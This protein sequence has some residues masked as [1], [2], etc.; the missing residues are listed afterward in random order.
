MRRNEGRLAILVDPGLKAKMGTLSLSRSLGFLFTN[1]FNFFKK[2][3]FFFYHVLY[4]IFARIL[5]MEWL[6]EISLLRSFTVQTRNKVGGEA[7]EAHDRHSGI[8]TPSRAYTLGV[9]FL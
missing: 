3:V 6:S 1:I 8:R 4:I 7:T 9:G 2:Q 5:A